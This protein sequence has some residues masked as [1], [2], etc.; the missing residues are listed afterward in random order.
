MKK[1]HFAVSLLTACIFLAAVVPAVALDFNTKEKDAQKNGNLVA[2]ILKLKDAKPEVLSGQAQQMSVSDLTKKIYPMLGKPVKITGK[3]YKVEELP[4]TEGMRGTWTEV[5][6]LAKNP[7]SPL[8]A[9]TIDF[10]YKGDSANLNANDVITV[11]GYLLGTYDSP[12]AV[13]GTV[14]CISLAGDSFDK[15]GHR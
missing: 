12:N 11:A 6:M 3:V 15:K 8:G 2:A 7:N 13:G 1:I 14:E 4:A 9:T 10:L 5:M